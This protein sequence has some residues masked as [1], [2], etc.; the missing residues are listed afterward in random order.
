[1]MSGKLPA[2]AA[3]VTGE[4]PAWICR[5]MYVVVPTDPSRSTWTAPISMTRLCG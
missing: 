5:E 4:S 1:M 2:S 3:T